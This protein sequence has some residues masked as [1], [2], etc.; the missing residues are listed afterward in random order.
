ME[1]SETTGSN[2]DN[3]ADQ[4]VDH[5]NEVLDNNAQ[6]VVR[7]NEAVIPLSNQSRSPPEL[8]LQAVVD[9]QTPPPPSISQQPEAQGERESNIKESNKENVNPKLPPLLSM[10]ALNVE[11][12]ITPNCT[13]RKGGGRADEFFAQPSL[14]EAWVSKAEMKKNP[15]EEHSDPF[16]TSSLLR[17]DAG[18]ISETGTGV[19]SPGPI[20]TPNLSTISYADSIEQSVVSNVGF[21]PNAAATAENIQVKPVSTEATVTTPLES[22]QQ[23]PPSLMSTGDP[24]VKSVETQ[25]LFTE[26]TELAQYMAGSVDTMRSASTLP[27]GGDERRELEYQPGS[28][29]FDPEHAGAMSYDAKVL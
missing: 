3:Q 20:K 27:H 8:K 7:G 23:D 4:V 14:P 10:V 28:T 6:V 18:E 25:D 1:T 5:R 29:T 12:E 26:S 16:K 11:S 9:P 22:T 19:P 13:P 17:H 2:H 15:Y 21:V 24:F